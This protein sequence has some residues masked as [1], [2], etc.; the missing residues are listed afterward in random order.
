MVEVV[1]EVFT[2]EPPPINTKVPH[3]EELS[4]SMAERRGREK[5]TRA[6]GMGG[7]VVDMPYWGRGRPAVEEVAR[8]REVTVQ[9][10]GPP[11][12]VVDNMFPLKMGVVPEKV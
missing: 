10:S 5:G 1:V 9:D 6:V 2:L 4:S 3:V 11:L 12:M 7:R 8:G